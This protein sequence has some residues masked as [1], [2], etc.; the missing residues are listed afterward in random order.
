M[1]TYRLKRKTYSILAP[2]AKTIS[3]FNN[4][5][6][7]FKAG[8]MGQAIKSGS[9]AAYRGTLGLAKGAAVAGTAGAIALDNIT[10]N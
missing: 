6:S 3:N 1:A 8:N 2:F 4:M 10:N 9:A 7:A 5:K